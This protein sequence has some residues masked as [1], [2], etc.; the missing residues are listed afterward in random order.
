M[1]DDAPEKLGRMSIDGASGSGKTSLARALFVRRGARRRFIF[2]PE[3]EYEHAATVVVRSQG[4]L[5]E[6]A[7]KIQAEDFSQFS[8]RF[9]PPAPEDISDPD[10][11][12]RAEGKDC[13]YLCSLALWLGNCL[14]AVDE[15]HTAAG[16]KYLSGHTLQLA[17][18]GR[19]RGAHLWT[20]SQR[21]ADIHVSVRTELKSVEAWYG[22]L[23]EGADLDV[24]RERRGKEF[25]DRVSH[26]PELHFLRLVP[27]VV[28]PEEWTVVFHGPEG[29]PAVPTI[30][31]VS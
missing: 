7:E 12:G 31:R 11:V 17:K 15:A 22:L 6:Y 8:V 1:H 28:E 13:G 27:R 4:E 9:V 2:D 14:T 3:D 25:A 29:S 16:R 24:L 5:H 30:E 23:V 20:M 19:K 26:L 21:P 18:K 10:E